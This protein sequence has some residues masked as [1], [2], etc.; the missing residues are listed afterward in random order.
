VRKLAGLAFGLSVLLPTLHWEANLFDRAAAALD[1]G[2]A[3][4][5]NDVT[6]PIDL[7]HALDKLNDVLHGA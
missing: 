1:D 4:S 7:T 5:T 3:L 2:H 6:P